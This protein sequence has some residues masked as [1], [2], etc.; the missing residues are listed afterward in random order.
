M[1]TCDTRTLLLDTALDLIWQSNYDSVGVNEICKQAG[2]TKGSFYHHF[3]SKAELFCEATHHH[4]EKIKQE[5][6]AILSPS[7][8]PLEQ[9]ENWLEFIFTNKIGKDEKNIPGCAFFSAANQIGCGEDRVTETVQ[10]M[11]RRSS[12]Y[13]L[14]LVTSLQQGK[15]LQDGIDA[16]V[17]ARQLQQY[18]HGA[19]SY[20]RVMRDIGNIKRDIPEG[21]YRLIGLKPEYWFSKQTQP[22]QTQGNQ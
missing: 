5:V 14:A 4:W 17:V 19:I 9:L 7:S 2:V 3:E 18:V 22:S 20:A 8:T 12:R 10:A 13:N 21:V 6:D 11:T 1:S 15:Y 16:E